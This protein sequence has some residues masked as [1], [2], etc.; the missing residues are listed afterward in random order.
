ML[1]FA[2][3]GFLVLLR[4]VAMVSEPAAWMLSGIVCWAIALWPLLRARLLK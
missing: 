4:G 2:L 3:V 1:A